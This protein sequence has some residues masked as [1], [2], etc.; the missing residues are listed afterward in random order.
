M[1]DEVRKGQSRRARGDRRFRAAKSRKPKFDR[2]HLLSRSSFDIKKNRL[3]LIIIGG[4]LLIMVCSAIAAY[5]LVFVQ[6]PRQ[7]LVRVDNVEYTR[8]D[9]VNLLRAQQRQVELQ[10]E[11]YKYGKTIFEGFQ[12]IIDNE[13]IAQS[14]P[15]FGITASEEDV[16]NWVRALFAPRGDPAG[17]SP[18]QLEREFKDRYNSF[19][20]ETQLS[21]KE[22]RRQVRILIVKQAMRQLIGESA[23]TVAEQ[24][25]LHRLI[26]G[27]DGEI[28]VM[29]VKYQDAVGESTDPDTLHQAF[30]EL[31]R[32]FSNDSPE[33]VRKGGDL[34]W[35]PRGIL[36]DYDDVIFEL[37]IGELSKPMPNHENR[38]QIFFFM[39]SEKEGLREIEEGKREILKTV[40]LQEWLNNERDSHDIYAVFNSEIYAWLAKQ[41]SLTQSITPVTELQELPR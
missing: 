10:G 14:A 16:D 27:S 11:H 35:S 30:K 5:V 39:V 12:E 19:L 36:P 40:A 37:E 34:D 31:V 1:P 3:T 2:R 22:H 18:N 29:Q 8:G 9:M 32:E 41:M 4:F 28:E 23:P 7:L 33:I 24:V 20:H 26:M 38:D 25:H 17:A 6:P 21:E 15:K 13:I